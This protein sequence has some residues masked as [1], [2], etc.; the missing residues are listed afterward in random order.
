[1]SL[2]DR[3]LSEGKRPYFRRVGDGEYQGRIHGVPVFV[4]RTALGWNPRSQKTSK[5]PHWIAYLGE[6]GGKVLSDGNT[7]MKQAIEGADLA[8]RVRGLFKPSGLPAQDE[9]EI[10]EC[11]KCGDEMEAW[12][13]PEHTSEHYDQEEADREREQDD[14]YG[15]PV[16]ESEEHARAK[17][18]AVLQQKSYVGGPRIVDVNFVVARTKLSA[19]QVKRMLEKLVAEKV[20]KKLKHLRR[21]PGKWGEKDL[22]KHVQVDKY[23]LVEDASS[24]SLLRRLPSSSP[25]TRSLVNRSRSSDGIRSSGS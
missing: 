20:V 23:Q 5:A 11:P 17:V 22:T 7:T 13:L 19:S 25:S 12:R 8:I 24:P 6:G 18:L 21:V 4:A 10:V 9:D 15:D 16:G 3:V 2:Y 1:M 14:D